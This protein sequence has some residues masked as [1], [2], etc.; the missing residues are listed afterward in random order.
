MKFYNAL[1]LLSLLALVAFSSALPQEDKDK[2]EP[3][4]QDGGEP[5]V[6]PAGQ[7]EISKNA[8]TRIIWTIAGLLFK[9]FG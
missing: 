9:L 7:E 3:S 1:I 6:I 2:V 8:T 5:I 4:D